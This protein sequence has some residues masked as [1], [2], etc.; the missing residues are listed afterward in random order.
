[1]KDQNQL[2]KSKLST[3]QKKATFGQLMSTPGSG[4]LVL[5]EAL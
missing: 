5:A 1:M 2:N 3:S 4:L